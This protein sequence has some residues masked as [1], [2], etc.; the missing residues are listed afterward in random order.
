MADALDSLQDGRAEAVRSGDLHGG[1]PRHSP[2]DT[3]AFPEWVDSL[4]PTSHL[5]KHQIETAEKS[6]EFVLGFTGPDTALFRPREQK[7]RIY[8]RDIPLLTILR[9][10]P[11]TLLS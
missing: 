4:L 11:R 9:I 3:P 7:P 6:T 2:L 5:E 10:L 1:T 8:S